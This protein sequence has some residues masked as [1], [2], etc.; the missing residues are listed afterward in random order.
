MVS[1]Y[2]L[3]VFIPTAIQNRIQPGP[4]QGLYPIFESETTSQITTDSI[5]IIVPVESDQCWDAPL[6]CTPYF[7]NDLELRNNS[8][9]KDGF[10]FKGNNDQ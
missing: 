10:K 9:L 7:K 1:A 4:A 2:I 6:P 3:L 8:S 5:I